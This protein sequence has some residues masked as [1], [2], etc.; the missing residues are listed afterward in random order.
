MIE[1]KKSLKDVFGNTSFENYT[2]EGE[3]A[4]EVIENIREQIEE[5]DIIYSYE[6]IK[7]LKEND[8]SLGSSLEL[9]KNI[10]YTI[11]DINS[12][13][14]ATL[15]YQDNLK[16]ELNDLISNIEEVFDEDEK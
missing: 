1:K 6:A 5:E 14:L 8:I 10:G 13:L 3:D 16:D 9:A 12:G 2:Y 7:Y 11:E 4:D 15:L